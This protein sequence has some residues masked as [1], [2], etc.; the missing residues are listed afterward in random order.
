MAR[1]LAASSFWV[2][3]VHLPIVGLMQADLFGV[4]IAPGTKFALTLGVTVALGL[5]SFEVLVRRT[6]LGRFLDGRTVAKAPA[7]GHGSGPARPDGGGPTSVE[8][9]AAAR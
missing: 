1:Y 9:A 2:Y 3:L 8:S 4:A 6:A 5:S 7:V